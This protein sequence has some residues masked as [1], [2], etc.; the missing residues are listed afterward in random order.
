MSLLLHVPRYIYLMNDYTCA[1]QN[2]YNYDGDLFLYE[3]ELIN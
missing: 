1:F 3:L 2:I